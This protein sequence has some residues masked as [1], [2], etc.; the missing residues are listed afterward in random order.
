MKLFCARGILSDSGTFEK[1]QHA[2]HIGNRLLQLEEEGEFTILFVDSR[3]ASKL[4]LM[5][6]ERKHRD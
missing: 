5:A 3:N 2:Q 1:E 4:R 6:Q